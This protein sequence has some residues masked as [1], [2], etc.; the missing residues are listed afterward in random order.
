[1]ALQA[2]AYPGFSNMKRLGVF[3]LP[4]EWDEELHRESRV[5]CPRTLAMRP[6]RTHKVE[7]KP[8]QIYLVFLGLIIVVEFILFLRQPHAFNT[9]PP[10]LSRLRH[11][12]GRLAA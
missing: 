6:L 10:D 8:H 4:P 5:P 3:L 12:L 11:S 2:G 1:M 7:S 9:H